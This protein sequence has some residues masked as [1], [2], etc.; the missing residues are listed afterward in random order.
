MNPLAKLFRTRTSRI[1]AVALVI[2]ILDQLTKALVLRFLGYHEEMIIV[3]GFF[4][5]VH[6]QN[7]GAA[8]SIFTGNNKMLAIVATIALVV[9]FL[10]R[11]H[12]DSRSLPGQFALGLIFGGITGNLIDRLLPSRHAVVDFIY[13]YLQR[14]GGNEIGF[15]AFNIADSGICTGVGLIFLLTWRH[16]HRA[17]SAGQPRE[18]KPDV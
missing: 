16:E 7:T 1:A 14:S 18:S 6:W 12:F 3:P 13:F 8:W 15:P 4:K 10:G 2:V 5:F 11:H 17:K 9:L